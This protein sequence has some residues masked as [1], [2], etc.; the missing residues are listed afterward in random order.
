M[1]FFPSVNRT[2]SIKQTRS[3]LVKENLFIC[4][5]IRNSKGPNDAVHSLATP[6][7]IQQQ[8]YPGGLLGFHRRTKKDAACKAREPG[9]TGVAQE[10]LGKQGT[11]VRVE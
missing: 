3:D 5:L 11:C 9:G 2:H 8:V 10:A 4:K 1:I 6:H 7:T